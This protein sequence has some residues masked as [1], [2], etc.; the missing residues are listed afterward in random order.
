MRDWT[1][2]RKHL[3]FRVIVLEMREIFWFRVDCPL[4]LT[5]VPASACIAIK[6]SVFLSFDRCISVVHLRSLITGKIDLLVNNF[7]EKRTKRLVY[8]LF[9]LFF[10]WK[11]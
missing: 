7:F 2:K 11:K 6:S 5:F 8:Q 10:F 3:M 1:R 4:G 9:R